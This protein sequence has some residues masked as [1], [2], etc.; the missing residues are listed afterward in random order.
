MCVREKGLV[1]VESSTRGLV[2]RLGMTKSLVD[3][4]YHVTKISGNLPFTRP[5]FPRSNDFDAIE[6]SAANAREEGEGPPQHLHIITLKEQELTGNCPAGPKITAPMTG[7]RTYLSVWAL[8]VCSVLQPALLSQEQSGTCLHV[9]CPSLT[10]TGTY[11]PPPPHTWAH[12]HTH[13]HT[14]THRHTGAGAHT[15]THTGAGARAHTHT[16]THMHT[17]RH[18]HTYRYTQAHTHTH[19]HTHTQ[20]QALSHVLQAIPGVAFQSTFSRGRLSWWV[21]SLA[22]HSLS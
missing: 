21:H 8:Y 13:T 4:V 7:L 2:G 19:T 6:K 11:S 15:H 14:H 5:F 3:S 9:F 20:A 10:S 17:Q 22:C 18:K 1:E 12:R 16:H